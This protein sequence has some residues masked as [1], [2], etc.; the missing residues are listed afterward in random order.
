MKSKAVIALMLTA[1]LLFAVIGCS[2]AKT[3]TSSPSA[4]SV[5]QDDTP[6]PTTEQNPDATLKIGAA[7]VD[8]NNV[9]YAEMYQRMV[10]KCN[11][12]GI[13]LLVSSTGNDTAKLLD[14]VENFHQAGCQAM[15]LSVVDPALPTEAI[16]E[17]QDDGIFIL[18]TENPLDF[19]DCWSGADNTETG[20]A[21][22]KNATDWI[23]TTF[24]QSEEVKICL[25]YNM[26]S[27]TSEERMAGV[28]T[29]LEEYAPNAKIVGEAK[30]V[31]NAQGVAAGENF[32]QAYPDLNCVICVNDAGALGVLEAFTAANFG[33]DKVGIFGCDLNEQ[34][35]EE[36]QNTGSM[37]RGSVSQNLVIKAGEMI[38]ICYAA[39]NGQDYPSELPYDR[40]AVTQ[41]TIA[42]YI[43]N[44]R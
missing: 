35:I 39:M 26:G 22:G 18:T 33:G 23:N 24:D 43:A 38:D 29:A 11:E 17:A 16:K 31:N 34:A 19:A 41:E 7:L 5:Q 1:L 9:A 40:M 32:M 20:K 4:A 25:V 13:E 37:F 30:G 8:L 44:Y 28:R 15:I 14:A 12:Y 36:L 2:Q 27:L 42:D 3:D 6:E 21:L 10:E